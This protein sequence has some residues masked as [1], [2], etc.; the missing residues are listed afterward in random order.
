MPQLLGLVPEVE[1]VLVVVY[2][3]QIVLANAITKKPA[4]RNEDRLAKFDG[5]DDGRARER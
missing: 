2:V 5:L 1:Q 3:S 4:V